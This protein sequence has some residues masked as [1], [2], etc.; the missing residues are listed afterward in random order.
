MSIEAVKWALDA[1][2]GGNAKVLLIGLANHAHPDGS[3]SYPSLDTLARYAHCDKSTARRNVRK[4]A[5]AGWIAEDGIGPRGQT[6]Y[7][8]NL[9]LQN[10]TGSESP[11]VANR[12]EGVANGAEGGGT[13]MPPEPSLE[14]SKEPSRDNERARAVDEVWQ[15]YQQ[16][17]PN[18]N[19]YRLDHARRL[20]ITK[21]LQVRTV[22]ECCQAIDGLARSDYHVQHG[23]LDI[24]YALRGGGQGPSPEATI[25][26]LCALASGNGHQS[27]SADRSDTVGRTTRPS[28]YDHLIKSGS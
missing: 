17:I 27:S 19:R 14:P 3:E 12:Q 2:L 16:T 22:A 20:I 15:R 1:P 21:A 13:A 7:R 10:A 28:R 23:Y 9:G 4:L 5:D 11:R 25:D 26:R 8:L 24:K 6:K 18:G